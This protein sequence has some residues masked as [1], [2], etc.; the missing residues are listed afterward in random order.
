MLKGFR[1]FIMRGNVVDLAVAVV[2]GGAFGQ[3]VNSLVAD[4]L[5]PL[6]G[7]LGGAPD[8]SAIKLGPIALGK[9]INTVV[10]FLVVGVAIYFL[11]VVPMQEIEKRRKKAEETAPPPPPEPSEEVKLLREILSELRRK[12]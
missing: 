3:V 6:I 11:I 12:A 8:F 7:A 1:D 10:N 9:F 5:T 2:I 4:I